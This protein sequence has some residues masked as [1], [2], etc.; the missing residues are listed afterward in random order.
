M[1][2]RERSGSAAG[3]PEE[4][5]R[6]IQEKFAELS[7]NI[8]ASLDALKKSLE[9]KIERLTFSEQFIAAVEQIVSE[10]LKA[11]LLAERVRVSSEILE[12]A[13]R[14][15]QQQVAEFA[16]SLRMAQ[17]I[18]EEIEKALPAIVAKNQEIVE[19]ICERVEKRLK[20]AAEEYAAQKFVD[21]VNSVKF[22][23]PGLVQK[24]LNEL[25]SGLPGQ[26]G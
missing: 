19:K 23:V 21:V 26:T 9:E 2:N 10:S 24:A 3:Q 14:V 5:R 12:E 22:E 1:A 15:A 7:K 6:E 11:P 8:S 25:R 4:F 16:E 17:I 18:E 13:Q 20:S